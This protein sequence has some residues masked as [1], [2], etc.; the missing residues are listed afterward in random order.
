MKKILLGTVLGLA[1]GA[2]AAWLVLSR[3]AEASAPETTKAPAAEEKHDGALHWT[4]EQQTAAGIVVAPAVPT[5]VKPELEAFGRVLDA[6][7]IAASRGEIEA[8]QATLDSS[9]KELERVKLL[10]SQG[11]NASAR[12]LEMADAAMKRDRAL[13]AGAWARL[14]AAWGPALAHRDDLSELSVALLNQT[15]ALLRIDL[16]PGE[17]VS[18]A[19]ETVRLA[20]LVGSGNPAEAEILGPAPSADPQ[21][22]GKAFLALLR[23]NA[24]APGALLT[25]FIP[26][27]G[28][29]TKGVLLPRSS[30]IRH[31]GEAFVWLQTG[32][33]AFARHRVELGRALP[34][35]ILALSGVAEGDKVVVTGGQQL[36]SDELKA[37][38]GAE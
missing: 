2:T 5:E 29:A 6:S 4:R 38:G 8:A 21:T 9:S 30:I 12:A 32:E 14:T 37:G 24:P 36:L 20:A 19:P 33:D 31:D 10:R 13:L 16:L 7:S 17:T 23:T 15:A 11:D 26:L 34:S 27:G 3:H 18:S 22:Q 25:A 28:E 1:L 35:G